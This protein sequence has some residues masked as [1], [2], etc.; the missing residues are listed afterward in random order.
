MKSPVPSVMSNASRTVEPVRFLFSRPLYSDW[1]VTRWALANGY[2]PV[3]ADRRMAQMSPVSPARRLEVE[4]FGVS[5]ENKSV[6]CP[7]TT[8][9]WRTF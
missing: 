1:F 6:V 8:A 5:Q 3:G 4:S 2:G 9:I 7:S